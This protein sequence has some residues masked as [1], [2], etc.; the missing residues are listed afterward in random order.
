MADDDEL[1]AEAASERDQRLIGDLRR[2]YRAEAGTAQHVARVRHRL[3]T[4][5]DGT[6]HERVG[7]SLRHLPLNRQPGN[8]TGSETRSW[9]P[10]LSTLAAV[11]FVGVLVG[12]LLLVLS[13]THRGSLN[14]PGTALHTTKPAGGSSSLFSLHMIDPTTGWA[15]SEHEI[16]RTADG[17]LHWKNVTPAGATITRESVASFLTASL[18]WVATPQA[19]GTTSQIVR[20]A[21]SGQTWQQSTVPMVYLKQMTF[22]DAQHGWILVGWNTGGGPAEAVA[23]F[24]SIDGGKTWRNVSSALPASTDGP[25]PGRLPFGGR[26][27]GIHFLNASTGWITGTVGANDLSWLYVSHDGGATWNRQSLPL[28]P[29]VP[30]AQFSLGSPTFFSGTDG[31]LPVIFSDVV[32]ERGFATDIYVTHDGGKTWTST[33]PLPLASVAID[34]ADMQHGW[35]TDGTIL[36]RT[37]N[38]GQKWTKLSPGVTFK[39]VTSLDFVSSTLGWAIGGPGKNSSLVLKTTDGGES[40]M[41][42]PLSIS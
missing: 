20:T 17:G 40:W 6:M 33:A 2:M 4:H 26:K 12:S 11:L 15:L 21:D 39:Q 28:L 23:V 13:R 25:P 35:A 37:S 3:L 24:R 10:R 36:Y 16:L 29:G 34:F 41:T 9:R 30:S 42:V 8:S 5:P 1:L 22:V 7:S 32:T 27:S 14:A 18:A 19:N 31:V 38:G